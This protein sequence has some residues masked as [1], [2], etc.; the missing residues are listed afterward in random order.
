META[1]LPATPRTHL[2]TKHTRRMRCR[3][4]IPAIVYGHGQTPEPIALDAHEIENVIHHHSRVLNVEIDGKSNQYFIKVVQYDHLG[5][6]PIH[7]DLMRVDRDERVRVAVEVVLR[8]TPKG[9]A[10]GGV[11]VQFLNDVEV[12]CI[13]TAIPEDVRVSVTHLDLGESLLVEELK[14]PPGVTVLADAQDKVATC[15][16]PTEKEEV[17]DEETEEAEG[18]GQPEVIG[19]GK[20]EESAKKDS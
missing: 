8:G 6:T 13:M 2:G 14:L 7:L 10:D 3:G 15:R 20:E 9:T 12:E 16:I 18:T 17:E 11:L 1:S 19:R 4:Q 5:T